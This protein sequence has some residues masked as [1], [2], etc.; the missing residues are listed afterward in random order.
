MLTPD[1]I[2]EELIRQ[3][4]QKKFKANFIAGK[5][6]IAPARVTE[7]RNKER[8]VQ[9]NEMEPL[10]EL[11]GL[12]EKPSTKPRPVQSEDKVEYWGKVAQGIW[13]EQSLAPADP[14]EQQFVTYDRMKGDPAPT[15]LFAV[16]P[17]G[18]SMNVAF[19]DPR[20]RLICRRIVFGVGELVSGDYVIV[21]RTA[22][23]LREM[24]CKRV[25]ID[26]D[27]CFWLHCEST[28]ERWKNEKWK[29]GKPSLN[30]HTDRE[31]TV[32]AKVIRAVINYE[33]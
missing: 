6:N 16:E 11:L 1:V 29:M 27:G 8:R 5:L 22:H 23:D 18:T 21:E 26:A 9:P 13:L 24:T 20:T 32:I 12:T 10:A 2:R 17:E 30:H 31:I 33:R 7:M 14:D 25:E 19:P 15:D 28:D 3:L 4:D